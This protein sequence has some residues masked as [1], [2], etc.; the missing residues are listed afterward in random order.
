MSQPICNGVRSRQRPYLKN[1]KKATGKYP[2]VFPWLLH[3]STW[4]CI[5]TSISFHQLFVNFTSYTTIRSSLPSLMPTLHPCN[6]LNNR[7]RISRGNCSVSQ[8]V[9]QNTVLSA[10]LCLQLCTVLVWFEASDLCYTH[11]ESSWI[12]FCCPVP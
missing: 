6:L 11:W 1:I 5:P 7:E 3:A 8:C 10:L 2:C 12:F 9:P 4:T